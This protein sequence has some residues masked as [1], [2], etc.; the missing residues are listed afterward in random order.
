MDTPHPFTSAPALQDLGHHG[1]WV[2]RGRR[3]VDTASGARCVL[4]PLPGPAEG[5]RVWEAVVGDL[6]Q[7]NSTVLAVPSAVIQD[8]D[9]AWLVHAD[10]PSRSYAD[11]LA[12]LGGGAQSRVLSVMHDAAL[13]MAE[14]HDAGYAL[15]RLSLRDVLATDRSEETTDG[16]EAFTHWC[17]AL[18]PDSGLR[19]LRKENF[20]ED[21]RGDLIM[22]AVA[23]ATVLTGR[24]PTAGRVRTPLTTTCPSLPVAA[25]QALEDLLDDLDR[26]CRIDRSE[27]AGMAADHVAAGD[28]ARRLAWEMVEE[29]PAGDARGPRAGEAID[30]V[31][32]AGPA[33]RADTD[34]DGESVAISAAE[35]AAV[36]EPV[37]GVLPPDDH[38]EILDTVVARSDPETAPT[39]R[40]R[41]GLRERAREA[42]RVLTPPPPTSG[43]SPGCAADSAIPPLTTGRATAAEAAANPVGQPSAATAALKKLSANPSGEARRRPWGATG[44]HAGEEHEF[45]WRRDRSGAVTQDRAWQRHPRLV[46]GAAV[47]VLIV[48]LVVAGRAVIPGGVFSTAGT[49]ETTAEATPATQEASGLPLSTS[50]GAREPAPATSNPATGPSVPGESGQPQAA[51]GGGAEENSATA[52]GTGAAQTP[53][54]ALEQLIDRRATALRTADNSLLE[55]VYTDGAADRSADEATVEALSVEPQ[56]GK[57]PFS[58]LSMEVTGATSEVPDDADQAVVAATVTAAGLPEGQPASQEVKFDLQRT[59]EGWRIRTVETMTPPD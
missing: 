22:L 23:A 12:A 45:D 9:A 6:G 13:A 19:P 15:R 52:Q 44:V 34:P 46:L 21:V 49:E 40:G 1:H 29:H 27:P 48:G 17:L 4:L 57:H 3:M 11:D 31:P 24:R 26:P 20:E 51:H 41:Q 42:E 32:D 35:P 18:T 43:R 50:S 36:P 37:H 59:P 25:L 58:D 16:A 38:T 28:F 54:E 39:A 30:V 55:E 8:G 14:L 33:A 47:V 10:L 53:E 56:T 7:V 2:G 5:V